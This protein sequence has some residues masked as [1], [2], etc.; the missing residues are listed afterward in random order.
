MRY[1]LT[2]ALLL[3]L[4]AWAADLTARD[5]KDSVTLHDVPCASEVLA[6]KIPAQYMPALHAMSA[7]IDGEKFAG[8]WRKVGDAVH[9]IFDDGDQGLAP[10]SKFRAP[11][12]T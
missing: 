9:L 8:C 3:A 10:L 2:L 4:P 5:G 11:M 6:G 12:D 1:I 7:V